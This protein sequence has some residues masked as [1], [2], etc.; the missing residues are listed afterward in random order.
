MHSHVV[1]IL[2]E[3]ASARGYDRITVKKLTAWGSTRKKKKK[4]KNYSEKISSRRV[5]DSYFSIDRR[6]RKK[7]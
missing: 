6:K 1:W 3:R 2:R 5:E 4:K 7:N